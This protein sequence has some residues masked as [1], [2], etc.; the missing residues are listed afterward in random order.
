M[1]S[2]RVVATDPVSPPVGD[3]ESYYQNQGT[4]EGACLSSPYRQGLYGLAYDR[5]PMTDAKALFHSK[6][7]I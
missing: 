6:L 4:G 5:C 1:A 7:K 3:F 2:P